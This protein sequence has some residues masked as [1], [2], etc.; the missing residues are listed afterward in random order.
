MFTNLEVYDL[1]KSGSRLPIQIT[2][3]LLKDKS[4]NNGAQRDVLRCLHIPA[5]FTIL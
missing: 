1:T 5:N 3:I 4:A 2:L